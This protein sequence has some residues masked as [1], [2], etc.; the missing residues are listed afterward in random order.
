MRE[1]KR[2]QTMK[3]KSPVRME[4]TLHM[5]F[6]V[7]GWKSLL[8]G[9]N[10]RHSF[11]CER[12]CV[13]V[14]VCACVCMCVRVYVCVCVRVCVREKERVCVRVYVCLRASVCVCMCVGSGRKGGVF[15]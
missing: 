14:S 11:V 10:T 15:E 12:V 7:S 13:F 1:K 5:G 8:G 9:E 4:D 3:D 6:Q 2:E